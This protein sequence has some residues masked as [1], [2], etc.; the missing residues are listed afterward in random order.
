MSA[1]ET[2]ASVA[3]RCH[4][5]AGM[6]V[7]HRH[8]KR[9]FIPPQD[10]PSKRVFWLS[11]FQNGPGSWGSCGRS[12]LL[13]ASGPAVD[14]STPQLEGNRQLDMT[15][16]EFRSAITRLNAAAQG[17]TPK[18]NYIMVVLVLDA[19]LLGAAMIF[20]GNVEEGDSRQPDFL[21]GKANISDCEC[22]T[23]NAYSKVYG[24]C[25]EG[26][27]IQGTGALSGQ[28]CTAMFEE[29]FSA[30]FDS[31]QLEKLFAQ[32]DYPGANLDGVMLK[33]ICV[34]AADE[35]MRTGILYSQAAWQFQSTCAHK[36]TRGCM[37]DRS[38]RTSSSLDGRE[39]GDPSGLNG[40]VYPSG[41]I[42][43]EPRKGGTAWAL[44]LLCIYAALAVPTL[45]FAKF[46]AICCCNQKGP[47][48]DLR[49]V[50]HELTQ[51]SADLGRVWTYWSMRA[52]GNPFRFSK[53]IVVS[54][55]E[56][57]GVERSV[58][59]GAKL[60]II[61]TATVRDGA[62]ISSKKI[63]ELAPG[64]VVTVTE[65]RT[66][67][68]HM[69][70]CIGEGRWISRVLKDGKVLAELADTEVGQ[71]ANPVAAVGVA[72]AMQTVQ[73]QCPAGCGPGSIVQSEVGGKMVQLTIPAGVSEG[74]TFQ[75]Q[76]A[77]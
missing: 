66:E 32:P 7:H 18:L 40:D 46:Q 59:D 57:A 35:V 61:A 10:G 21:P 53:C 62:R 41:C 48:R 24:Y 31:S 12:E 14:A 67:D 23:F 20:R 3:H 45:V 65:E 71:T 5:Y 6:V 68:G 17:Y 25:R 43:M 16:E 30:A 9:Y 73:M 69:R 47:T 77:V 11:G 29:D 22:R 8:K 33:C 19:I 27:L 44:M 2:A 70:V 60:R 15:D 54:I 26:D 39:S 1:Q 37:A 56:L 28:N 58:G 76:V 50:C 34:A 55:G 63:G 13:G 51:E 4:L 74:Q 75:V 72:Q 64:D 49:A 42:G 36:C 52:R 38:D